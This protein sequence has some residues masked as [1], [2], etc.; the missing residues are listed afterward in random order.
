[1]ILRLTSI[2][3]SL[4]LTTLSSS[5]QQQLE[6]LAPVDSSRVT[7]ADMQR[8]SSEWMRGR[9][10]S[11]VRDK[12]YLRWEAF[13][14]QRVSPD[15]S[16]A[17][18]RTYFNAVTAAML[19]REAHAR[20]Q[21]H[22]GEEPSWSPV[23]PLTLPRNDDPYWLQG[24]GRINCVAFHP[25]DT[26]TLFVGVAQ[27]GVW[28]SVD[29]GESWRPLTDN[30]PI[31]RISDIAIDPVNP[32][33]MYVSV[34]DFAYIGVDLA[35]AD[36]KRNTHYGLGVYKTTDG[37]ETW[38]PTGLS[39][40]LDDF[41]GSLIRRVFVHPQNT[42]RLLAAGSSGTWQ[43]TD[44]GTTWSHGLTDF[45]W[46]IERDPSNPNVLYASKGYLRLFNFGSTAL[47]KSVD[48]GATWSE[49]PANLPQR[50]ISRM[51]IAISPSNPNT[52]YVVAATDVSTF[53]SFMRSTDAGATWTVQAAAPAAKNI[54][55]GGDGDDFYGQGMYDLAIIV[56]PT[57][58]DRVFVGG[59]NIW[60]SE[61]GGSTWNIVTY[62]V[63]ARG[64][65]IHADHHFFAYNNLTSRYYMCNDGGINT[66][67]SLKISSWDSARSSEQFRWPTNWR[68][69]SS[70]LAITSF[71]R[72]GLSRNN[73]GY[74]V[75]GAQDNA[76]YYFDRREWKHLFGGDG[77]ECLIDPDDPGRVYGSSQ[78]GSIHMTTGGGENFYYSIG[79]HITREEV[80]EW[81]T[82]MQLNPNNAR[83]L[84]AAYGNLWRSDAGDTNWTKLSA[85]PVIQSQDIPAPA[86]ALSVSSADTNY[87]YLAKRIWHSQQ[88][89][90]TAWMTTDGGTTWSDITS[91]L[92]DSLYLTSIAT[93]A[94]R[95]R[96]AWATFGG[97]VDG[98]KVYKTVDA[99]ITWTNV[100]DNLPNLPVNSIVHDATSRTNAVFVGTDVGVYYR[101]D[102]TEGWVPL[103][104][105]LPNVIVSDLEMHQASRTLYAA[106][107]GRGIWSVDLSGF[108]GGAAEETDVASAPRLNVIRGSRSGDIT[109]VIASSSELAAVSLDIVDVLGRRVDARE[110]NVHAGENRVGLASGL[111]QGLYFVRLML[112]DRVARVERFV[113]DR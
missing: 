79:R 89:P 43:S 29:D 73:A 68:N 84:Y 6:R 71:Y 12:W 52:V 60:G 70:G 102:S 83:T 28:K 65:S 32:A 42:S 30:L 95:P 22:S 107:F 69:L 5:A 57:N 97:F 34:G 44:A 40:K 81:T 108:A 35:H 103:G 58:R 1:M 2:V 104:R 62:W 100:T 46:D 101:S 77:M 53:H 20:T 3:A 85:F 110:I 21:L 27:G 18:A 23:G 49:L 91:G 10:A 112:A 93:H 4:L 19:D 105:N 109:V 66:T 64:P 75:G 96:I 86:S 72:L 50:A 78:F 14:A 56:D 26:N 99:G 76:S 25:R 15:G 37:G 13:N 11:Q 31:L 7:F 92:P 90:S 94:T 48:F 111:R 74:V 24:I 17:D 61:D 88:L 16:L 36:R 67:D 39:F 54:L 63:G 59:I 47:L 9:D 45:I 87:I 41:D 8:A 51:E 98:V 113:V 38:A 82:P 106:T 55:D 33:V 80:G